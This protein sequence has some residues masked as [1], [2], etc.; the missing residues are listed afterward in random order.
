M[1][2]VWEYFINWSEY[3]ITW[4]SPAKKAAI[5]ILYLKTDN[6]Y[7]ITKL[8]PID[9]GEEMK[10]HF[11]KGQVNVPE[12]KIMDNNNTNIIKLSIR[13]INRFRRKWFQW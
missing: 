12:V 1:S 4:E 10:K 11:Q 5:D 9:L 3:F 8:G 2:I 6:K 13:D 7:W